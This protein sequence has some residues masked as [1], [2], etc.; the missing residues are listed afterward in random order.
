MMRKYFTIFILL[1]FT[2]LAIPDTPPDG[3]IV[4]IE[5]VKHVWIAGACVPIED[6]LLVD[7]PTK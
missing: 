3:T 4:V 2:A 5:G 1:L 6:D 7:P